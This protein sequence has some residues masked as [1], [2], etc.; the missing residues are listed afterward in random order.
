MGLL[1]FSRHS[2][3]APKQPWLQ[4]LNL[5][6]PVE[7][8]SKARIKSPEEVGLVALKP[9]AE[10]PA[11]VAKCLEVIDA[12]RPVASVTELHPQ[13]VV[14]TLPVAQNPQDL[15]SNQ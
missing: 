11:D 7:G 9:N 14:E 6:K 5:Q 3:S 12:H 13:V 2:D 8:W 4:D 10:I 1:S 15:A